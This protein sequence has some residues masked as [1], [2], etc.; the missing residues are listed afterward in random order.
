LHELL[1]TIAVNL[2]QVNPTFDFLA[3]PL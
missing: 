2:C 3:H 1:I